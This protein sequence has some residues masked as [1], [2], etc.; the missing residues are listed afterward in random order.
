MAM[1]RARALAASAALFR[2]LYSVRE[3][4]VVFYRD[5]LQAISD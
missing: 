3:P 2:L 4:E 5:E 1:I